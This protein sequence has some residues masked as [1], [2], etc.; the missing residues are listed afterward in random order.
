MRVAWRLP[1]MVLGAASLLSGLLAG[2]ARLGGDW[3]LPGS[4]L[5]AAHGPLMVCGFL[6]TVIA[7]ERAVALR[8]G[9]ALLVPLLAG[10]GGLGLVLHLAGPGPQLLITAGSAGLAAVAVLFWRRQRALFTAIMALGA[11][12]WLYGN[13][14]WLGLGWGPGVVLAWGAFLVLTITGERLELSRF[15]NPPPAHRTTLL[16]PL[17]LLLAGTLAG[18]DPLGARLFGAG[19]VVLALWLWRYDAARV[20]VRRPGLTRYIGICLLSGFGWLALAG[21]MLLVQGLAP[22]GPAYDAALHALFVGFV[23]AMILGHAPVILPSV[24][25]VQVPF[26]PVFY[27]NLALLHG[28]LLLRVA[29]DHSGWWAGRI[30]GGRLNALAIVLFLLTT[31]VVVVQARRA[32]QSATR[33]R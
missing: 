24:L 27:L 19:L 21:G 32:V 18:T 15:I 28:S 3:P 8:Q 16:L 11:L 31:L 9:W 6:G 20:T 2:A 13:L 10:L 25:H 33:S 7:L 1:V 5:T 29:A 22:A 17:G 26:H 30:W 12:A 14:L 4:S 23:F